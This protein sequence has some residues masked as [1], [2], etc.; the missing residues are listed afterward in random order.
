M[1]DEYEEFAIQSDEDTNSIDESDNETISEET[2]EIDDNEIND[3]DIENEENNLEE[4]NDEED[5]DEEND[6]EIKN[7]KNNGISILSDVDS[8]EDEEDDE[9]E[10]GENYL[11]KFDKEI[12]H[13]YIVDLHPECLM[14]NYDEI[15]SLSMVVRDKNNNI[16]DDLH[17]T[18]PY[19]T[20]YEKARVLGQRA[21]QINSG[22]KVF[23]DVPDNILDG[24][25]IAELELKQKR[26]PF[27]IRRPL[28]SGGC[29]YWSLKDL[30]I[31][32]F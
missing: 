19:L 27:I 12:N 5:E 4:E 30:E 9:D 20:K 7:K 6:E 16:V 15:I 24:Y 28:S 14:N 8:E 10:D 29:E 23:V 32:G 21:K 13:N 25:I 22:A 26:I 18:L 3:D 31:I 11:Q 17:K 2:S 1:S